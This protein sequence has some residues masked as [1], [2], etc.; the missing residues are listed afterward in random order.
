MGSSSDVVV[1]N[2]N[3]VFSLILVNGKVLREH[4]F[5]GGNSKLGFIQTSMADIANSVLFKLF[6]GGYKFT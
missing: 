5:H 6:I 1:C 2:H 4:S 3:A